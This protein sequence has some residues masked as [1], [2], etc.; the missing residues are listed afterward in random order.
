MAGFKGKELYSI[1]EK[2]RV[3]F[4]AKM[5]KHVPAGKQKRNFTVTRGWDRQTCLQ[6][7]P[8]PEW[9]RI[10]ADLRAKLNPYEEKDR[11]FL[12]EVSEHAEEIV[13]DSA[14]RLCI[15]RHLIEHAAIE[16]QVLLVGV[17]D[18]IELW[19]PEK[20][21]DVQRGTVGNISDLAAEVMGRHRA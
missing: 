20:Y 11:I 13:L 6:V 18:H 7:Y 19:N 16:R 12:R 4:P 2:G 15:P 8:Q 9:E 17:F 10:E 14:G 1:D 3:S 21:A 5:L